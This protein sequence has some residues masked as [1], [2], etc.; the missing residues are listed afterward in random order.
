ML[1]SSHSVRALGAILFV[2]VA[3][4]VSVPSARG[5]DFTMQATQFSPSAIEPGGST[6][7]TISLSPL[8]GFNGSVSLSCAVTPVQTISPPVCAVSPATATPPTSGPTVTI[9][10]T[11]TTPAALYTVTITGTGGATTLQLPLNLTVLAVTP[12]YT[13]TVTSAITPTSVHA[14]SGATAVLT[15]SPVNGYTGSVTISCSAI[16]PAATPAP[17]CGFSPNPVVISGPT[18]QTSTLTITT[19]GTQ[20]AISHPRV[21][22]AVWLP[23]P[24]F[25][26]I[27]AGLGRAG[28]LRRR[29]LSLTVLC[30]IATGLFLLPACNS[31]GNNS[32]TTS[33]TGTPKN[34]YSFTLDASDA[35]SVAPSNGTQTVSLTVN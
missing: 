2:F 10:T 32:T 17:V 35:N 18:A 20:S 15:I 16:T 6:I 33:G 27:M 29:F 13:L 25:A 11:S 24:A 26:F 5:Q 19:S 7:S 4:L 31:Y 21:F 23:L 22:Y 3:L 12:A 9:T 8:N 30:M 1:K 14:G 28:K 34:T